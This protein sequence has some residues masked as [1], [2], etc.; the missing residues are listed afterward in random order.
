MLQISYKENPKGNCK[1]CQQPDRKDA[2]VACDDCFMW[3]HQSCVSLEV[4]PSE[5]EKWLCPR[6][7]EVYAK[8]DLA[9]K[10]QT[11]FDDLM[12]MQR[13]SQEAQLKIM[14]QMI[15]ALNVKHEPVAS[16]SNLQG[17]SSSNIANL[18]AKQSLAELPYFDGCYKVW[19]RFKAAFDSTTNAGGFS[20]LDNLNR[21]Q[22]YL[23]GRAMEAVAP[24]MVDSANVKFILQ[25]LEQQFGR[26]QLVYYTPL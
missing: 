15:M 14:Q 11:K 24:L 8:L 17:Q 10:D 9:K 7:V 5:E 18:L 23:K 12:K 4:L 21:L 25:R 22:K 13:E 2:M 20:D 19:P 16:G 3:F 26:P 6:C 1:L